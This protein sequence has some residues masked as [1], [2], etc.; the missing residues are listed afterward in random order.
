MKVIKALPE[1][2]DPDGKCQTIALCKKDLLSTYKHYNDYTTPPGCVL[3]SADESQCKYPSVVISPTSKVAFNLRELYSELQIN[4]NE[5]ELTTGLPQ[6]LVPDVLLVS[7]LFMQTYGFYRKE[8]VWYRQI[9]LAPLERVILTPCG[10]AEQLAMAFPAEVIGQLY[11]LCKQEIVTMQQDFDYILRAK[12]PPVTTAQAKSSEQSES[13]AEQQE[14]VLAFRVLEATPILQGVVTESTTIVLL[15]PDE[16]DVETSWFPHSEDRLSR[17][18]STRDEGMGPRRESAASA[19]DIQLDEEDAFYIGLPNSEFEDY[20]IEAVAISDYRLRSHCIVLP[21][22]SASAHGVFHCQTVW[23]CAA[24]SQG[25][26]IGTNFDDLTLPLANEGLSNGDPRLHPAL[27]FVYDDEFELEQYVPPNRLGAEYEAV[28]LTCAYVH[29][30]LLFFLYPETLSFSR[31]Y[32]MLVK[33]S[34]LY[35]VQCCSIDSYE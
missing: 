20:I 27:V 21:K 25:I 7:Q 9:T 30:E 14:H 6:P 2:K 26:T 34:R 24:P 12:L 32:Q 35:H 8:Q 28:D 13:S 31:R 5:L 23:V 3:L 29:P 4:P 10:T 19:S 15:P 22:Q 11:Q 18:R 1:G 33:V 17:R 16:Q